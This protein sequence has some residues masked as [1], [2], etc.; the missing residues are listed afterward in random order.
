M[1][2]V[3]KSFSNILRPSCWR[4][5]FIFSALLFTS[6]T[7]IRNFLWPENQFNSIQ[8]QISV[9]NN[10]DYLDHLEAVAID[11]LASKRVSEVKISP[12][13]VRFLESAYKKIVMNNE[14]I[15]KKK[16]KLN[17]HFIKSKTPFYFSLPGGH[18]FF[19]VGL[20]KKYFKNEEILISALTFELVKLHKNLF[21]KTQVV[22]TGYLRVEK[23]LSLT[24]LP[25]QVKIEI[26]KWVY[27]AMKRSGYDS[28]ALLNWI[29][30]QNKNT[31]DFTVQW[32]RVGNISREE[33]SLKNFMIGQGI[34]NG[35]TTT[36]GYNSSKEF[37]HLL[38]DI[39]RINI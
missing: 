20:V 5:F 27:F 16:L 17:F 9:E 30:I 36:A 23:M 33:F 37:Y 12:R 25:L 1:K 6:C 18:V 32:G 31:L 19:S 39:K 21:I 34:E 28:S 26:N 35:N 38:K 14:L 29:Q 8:K 10:A 15:F 13:S 11:Y 22:P 24:R 3:R 7:S 4:V 2:K